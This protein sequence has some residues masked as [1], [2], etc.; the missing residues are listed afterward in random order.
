M[1]GL[2]QERQSVATARY[3]L[4]RDGF[5]V[6]EWKQTTFA[7]CPRLAGTHLAPGATGVYKGQRL[8]RFRYDS[9]SGNPSYWRGF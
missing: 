9:A 5:T 3:A 4:R 8:D 2:A 6:Y 1:P 7:M